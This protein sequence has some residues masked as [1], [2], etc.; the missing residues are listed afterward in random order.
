MRP[1]TLESPRIARVELQ[2]FIPNSGVF[3]KTHDIR[4]TNE[5]EYLDLT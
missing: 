5:S 3:T 1:K 4:V 2:Q